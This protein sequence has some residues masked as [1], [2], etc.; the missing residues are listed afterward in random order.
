MAFWQTNFSSSGVGR[1]SRVAKR[2]IY[3]GLGIL[4]H[5]LLLSLSLVRP[6][7]LFLSV[8]KTSIKDWPL[9]V[10]KEGKELSLTLT[11][12]ILFWVK[13]QTFCDPGSVS[14]A[15]QT[16]SFHWN[17]HLTRVTQSSPPIYTESNWDSRK[18]NGPWTHSWAGISD[19]FNLI[20]IFPTYANEIHHFGM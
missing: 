7:W 3:S 11:W 4:L 14:E 1:T 12:G 9:Q 5:A 2:N 19:L 15:L 6:T 10:R 8:I 18:I 20:V 16:L 13:L 17:Y